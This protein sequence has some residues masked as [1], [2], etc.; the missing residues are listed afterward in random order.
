M[1]AFCDECNQSL[2]YADLVIENGKEKPAPGV[3]CPN[4]EQVAGQ[5]EETISREIQD[6]SEFEDESELEKNKELLIEDGR[7]TIEDTEENTEE[8]QTEED[9]EPDQSET[10]Q[11]RKD[12]NEDAENEDKEEKDSTEEPQG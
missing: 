9:T 11:D 12:Q 4:C 6:V 5:E 10:V 8:K 3:I 2:P 7:E 1:V